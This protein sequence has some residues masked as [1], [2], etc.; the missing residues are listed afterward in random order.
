MDRRITGYQNGG[1]F[2][3]EGFSLAMGEI[4]LSIPIAILTITTLILIT[5]LVGFHIKLN[6]WNQTTYEHAKKTYNDYFWPPF[7]TESPLKNLKLGIFV[8]K[9]ARPLFEPTKK[10]YDFTTGEKMITDSFKYPE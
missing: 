4:P 10:A 7:E 1:L 9:P 5:A 2:H 3:N 8:P 6:M